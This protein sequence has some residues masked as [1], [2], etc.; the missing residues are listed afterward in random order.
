MQ[1]FLCSSA[2][3]TVVLS[4]MKLQLLFSGILLNTIGYFEIQADDP[5]RAV[6]F[7]SGV[8]DWKFSKDASLP[9]EYWRIQTE[10]ANGGLLKHPAAIPPPQSGTNAFVCSI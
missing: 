8:F 7:Y 4:K 10:G 1:G 2:Y 9:I 3:S 6:K 5:E